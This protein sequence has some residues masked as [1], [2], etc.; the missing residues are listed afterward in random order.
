MCINIFIYKHLH[1]IYISLVLCIE[2]ELNTLKHIYVYVYT[3]VHMFIY[4]CISPLV[5]LSLWSVLTNTPWKESEWMGESEMKRK[6]HWSLVMFKGHVRNG[7]AINKS[8]IASLRFQA[9]PWRQPDLRWLNLCQKRETS[10]ITVLR[11]VISSRRGHTKTVKED[12]LMLS[13][14]RM[15]AGSCACTHMRI[16]AHTEHPSA[17][18]SAGLGHI[19]WTL[20]W[21]VNLEEKTL[22]KYLTLL[23]LLR[24]SPFS[25]ILCCQRVPE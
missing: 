18:Q 11:S 21:R 23:C 6:K 3:C 22:S 15:P 25:G 14:N 13:E 16:H 24:R 2:I 5:L 19:V 1:F 20:L 9:Y 10:R 8:W 4:F 12:L 7:R 17:T